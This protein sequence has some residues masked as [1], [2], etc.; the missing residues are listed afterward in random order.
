MVKRLEDRI[1]DAVL[2]WY[3]ALTVDERA[4]A[5]QRMTVLAKKL[6][7]LRSEGERHERERRLM[8]Q[9]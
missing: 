5:S 8:A 1:V 3:Q 4:E 7:N 9:L 6:L 2:A